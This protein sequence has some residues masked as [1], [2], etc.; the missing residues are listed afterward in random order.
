[1]PEPAS[2]ATPSARGTPGAAGSESAVVTTSTA[3]PRSREEVARAPEHGSP[4]RPGSGGQM[5]ET[6]TTLT[7]A[8]TS[9]T[10]GSAA[11]TSARS[12][13][14]HD[15]PGGGEHERRDEHGD[16]RAR[17]AP[18]RS[19]HRDER[20]GDERLEPVRDDPQPRPADRDGKR[21]RPAERELDR[22]GEQHDARGVDGAR[23]TPSR[24]RARRATASRGR[25]RA[26][27]RA[28]ARPRRRV[29]FRMPARTLRRSPASQSRVCSVRSTSRA[30]ELAAAS[31]VCGVCAMRK[32]PT[33]V[34][35]ETMPSTSGTSVV[36]SEM[37]PVAR[38]DWSDERADRRER[39]PR[40][41]AP[42]PTGSG[43]ARR[44]P[45]TETTAVEIVCATTIA[46][47]ASVT[48]CGAPMAIAMSRR[49]AEPG[50]I[51][52][53]QV[54]AAVQQERRRADVLGR[55]DEREQR[56]REERRSDAVLA[57]EL[58]G[59]RREGDERARV[60][61]APPT[62]LSRSICRK[63]RR[64]RPQSS[65]RD[66]AEPVLR[67]RLLDGEVEQRLEEADRD[68][69][70]REDA[71][72][73][74]PEDAG[75]DDRADDS[76]RDRGV[77]PRGRRRPAPEDAGGHRASQ[78]RDGL[79]RSR[80]R[81]TARIAPS[82]RAAAAALY[83]G[84]VATRG[85]STA[86]VSVVARLRQPRSSATLGALVLAASRSRS[87]SSTSAISPSSASG[88]ARRRSTCGFGRRRPRRPRRGDRVR[89]SRRR[90]RPPPAGTLL[91]LSGAALLAWLAF[92]VLPPRR[93][94]TT[95]CS[96]TTS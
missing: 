44:A 41:R 60:A 55:L 96:P 26:R 24:R 11:R 61:S 48:P 21:L 71:E 78:C 87:S 7:A 77:D 31:P 80:V 14:D 88:S 28:S 65:A 62:T 67:E 74:Q 25:T 4:G 69:R 40:A 22:R 19:E 34:G 54:V 51:R 1:M 27:R 66:V 58:V 8:A 6:T 64:S 12:R 29:Y 85:R 5:P 10:G 84:A 23:R 75:G 63:S 49:P 47:S 36:R 72:L 33:W 37:T 38:L 56:R 89:G 2:G 15:D 73:V 18:L 9:P 93:R 39:P 50:L 53:S 57:E 70:R 91:W 81:A 45:T 83:S 3:W 43:E 32:R 86:R 59:E 82:A 76:A 95:S 90:D 42:A 94:S 30:G 35:P 46:A 52:A 68:E 16:G 17:R 20:D 92:A 79:Q 13:Q